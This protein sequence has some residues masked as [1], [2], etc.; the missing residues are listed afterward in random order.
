MHESSTAG[1]EDDAPRE[2][3]A[4]TGGARPGAGRAD[5][6][7]TGRGPAGGAA[8][9]A[10]GG[11]A[12]TA[13]SGSGPVSGSG[14]ASGPGS[15]SGTA[16]GTASGSGDA[17]VAAE[18][19]GAAEP[20]RTRRAPERSQAEQDE[21][22]AALVA[23]FDDPVDLNNP[24]WPE[25]ENLRARNELKGFKDPSGTDRLPGEP[26]DLSDLA[27]QPRPRSGR[28]V[29][30]AAG[31]AGPR[32]FELSEET[33]EDHFVPPEPPPLPEADTTAKFA[34]LAVLGG[35]ALLLFD[36][37]V[38]R[39]VSGWPAWVGVASFLGGFAT[40]VV[41]MKDRDEDEPEDPHGG[42]VV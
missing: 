15:A 42:A 9:P 11:E 10:T 28:P 35:P 38:W 41:R 19:G 27:P 12:T 7:Q 3:G 24:N 39:E 32:D 16:S 6:E 37:V 33:D 5:G 40:L 21:I 29:M 23:Q 2:D 4:T 22:F 25:V 30:P 36:A 20:S 31:S 1:G 26:G 17:P 8:A 13:G 18:G 34:W 14:T